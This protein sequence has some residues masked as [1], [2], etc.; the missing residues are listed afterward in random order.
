MGGERRHLRRRVRPAAP[1]SRRARARRHRAVRP[2][3]PARPR[4]RRSGP[5]G[6]RRRRRRSGSTSPSSRSR[7]STRPRSSLDPFARTVDSLEAL[8]LDDPVFL[9]GADEFASFLDWKEPERVLELARLGVATRPG[10]DRENARRGARAR[11]SRP[12]RVTFFPIEPLRVS[13]S[14][15]RALVARGE[16]IDGLVP[17]AVAAEIARLGLYRARVTSAIAGTLR[18]GAEQ[19]TT[20]RPDLARASPPYRRSLRG[21]AG[22][23]RRDPRHAV[24]LRLHGLLRARDRAERAADEGDPRRGRGRAQARAAAAA[25]LDRAGCP[26]RPGSS[27]TTSTSCCTSSRPRRASTTGS[28]IS[29]T[30]CRSS[31]PLRRTWVSADFSRHC[32]LGSVG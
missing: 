11:L 16:P 14:E 27:T 4:R 25:A 17:A 3:P 30:T 7:R 26:R 19:R 22:D 29:G 31:R 32:H 12:E 24:G 20:D 28:R 9:V 8:A 1:R 10:V 15:I 18:D 5:Q 23:R 13:S 6:G 21:E 2:R